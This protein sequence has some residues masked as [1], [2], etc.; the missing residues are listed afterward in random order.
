MG[1]DLG[2]HS[3]CAVSYRLVLADQPA[4]G[5][6]GRRMKGEI[7]GDVSSVPDAGFGSRTLIWWGILGFILIEGGGF[8][9]AA[10]AYLFLMSHTHPW[11]P[12][13]PPNLW[14]G[15]LFTLVLAASEAPNIFTAKAAKAQ[16]ERPAIA[17]LF[18]MLAVGALLL[19]LRGFEFAN[20]NVRW[21]DNTYGSIVWALMFLH[22]THLVTDYADTLVL[23]AFTLSH[24]VDTERFSDIADN[25][26][27]WRFVVFAWL[28]IYALIYWVPRWI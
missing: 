25:A 1:G 8:V 6:E 27:Y 21:D 23:T 10:G 17:G 9:L 18:M 7:V 20:L 19:V 4:Q 5:A 16:K 13:A 14:A 22:T 2:R 12:Q 26:M 28:P 24:E 3:C 11:P 15:A